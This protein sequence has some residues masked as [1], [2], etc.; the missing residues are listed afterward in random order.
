MIRKT[1]IATLVIL[2]IPA[3]LFLAYDALMLRSLPTPLAARDFWVCLGGALVILL[4]EACGLRSLLRGQFR[5][6]RMLKTTALSITVFVFLIWQVSV[7]L[8]L[9]HRWSGGAWAFLSDGCLQAGIDRS[10]RPRSWTTFVELPTHP[11]IISWEK[12]DWW[13]RNW[14]SRTGR[15]EAIRVPLWMVY[16]AA[17]TPTLSLFWRYRRLPSGFCQNCSYDLTGNI[18]GVC[19]ECGVAVV[20]MQ[21]CNTDAF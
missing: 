2:G 19:P 5:R 8:D 21:P 15:W 6:K 10:G 1:V 16:S 9:G 17:L 7:V 14:W 20:A 12:I 11:P 18:S 4:L 3:G 13:P